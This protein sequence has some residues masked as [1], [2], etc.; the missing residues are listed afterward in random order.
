[1]GKRP[2]HPELLDWLAGYFVE[3]DWSVKQLH[4]LI[5]RSAAYQQGGEHPAVERLREVD[6]EN[7]LL[8]YYPPRRLTAE[9]LRDSVL[10]VAG[11]LSLHAGGPGTFPEINT[12]VALQPRQIMGTIAPV[13]HE[14][15][16]R[17]E[18]H[19]R[20]IYTYQIRNL[21]NPMLEVFNQPNSNASCER[22][23]AT[24]V[25]PQAF[26]L[27][28]GQFVHDMALAM[29]NRLAGAASD[30]A[31][32]IEH[33][34]Q[35][36]FG[37]SPTDSERRACL[38]HLSVATDH[39]RSHP[40]ITREVPTRVVRDHVGELTGAKFEFIEDWSDLAHQPNLQPAEVAAEVRALAEVCLVLLNANEFVYVY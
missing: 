20:T 18:R 14:S 32:Q 33:G 28:N 19:R 25:T 15:A 7:K 4:R 31:A 29:A 16:T 23:D 9:E 27:M 34:F 17:E 35:L 26:T 11:E 21:P 39:H 3:Q 12:D 13:Y 8:A 2:S 30:P 10:A 37:R 1:M 36:C 6:P 24:T 22:R 40:P 5:M 38:D